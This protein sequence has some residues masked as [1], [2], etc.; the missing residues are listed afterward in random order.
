MYIKNNFES[1]NWPKTNVMQFINFFNDHK[2][3]FSL[4]LKFDRALK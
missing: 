3:M 1:S 2:D 4:H